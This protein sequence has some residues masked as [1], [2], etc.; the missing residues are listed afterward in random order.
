M[1]IITK[2]YTGIKAHKLTMIRP[3]EKRDRHTVVWEALCDCGKTFHVIPSAA[4]RGSVKS[5]GCEGLIARKA[6]GMR[7][8][9]HDPVISSAKQVWIRYPGCDF[10]KFY[11]M[12]QQPCFY[13]NRPPY[14]IYNKGTC[15]KTSSPLQKE[16][17]NF[18]YNGIDRIDS[19]LGY[20]DGNMVP[21]CVRCNRAK[22]D[23]TIDEFLSLISLIYHNRVLPLGK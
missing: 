15:R 6:N 2:D 5:C 10:E 7:R 17:G 11:A 12:S 8:R 4:I 1:P 14:T 23:M 16:K 19:S 20:I 13:C 18:T 9:K 21:S 3:T 22:N